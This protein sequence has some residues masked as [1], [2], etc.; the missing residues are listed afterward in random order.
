[1]AQ[2]HP[3]PRTAARSFLMRAMSLGITMART[4]TAAG[5]LWRP[6]DNMW[7]LLP[8]TSPLTADSRKFLKIISYLY[9]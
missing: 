1:M 8:K 4:L 9:T 3:L 6:P 7:N 2:I 5:L